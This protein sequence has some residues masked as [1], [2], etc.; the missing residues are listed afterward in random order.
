M[1]TGKWGLGDIGTEGVPWKQGFDEFVGYL[2]LSGMMEGEDALSPRTS[3]IATYA[4]CG[5]ANFASAARLAW[6]RIVNR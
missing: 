5:F 2:H 4:L 3:A 6:K 1:M